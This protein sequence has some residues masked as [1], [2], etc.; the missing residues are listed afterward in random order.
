MPSLWSLL[1]QQKNLAKKGKVIQTSTLPK[2]ALYKYN[3]DKYTIIF[4]TIT[5]QREMIRTMERLVILPK[6]ISDLSSARQ[7]VI[8]QAI[9][10]GG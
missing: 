5:S 1:L 2:F 7:C 10:L 9:V 6:F 3:V 4:K 8:I